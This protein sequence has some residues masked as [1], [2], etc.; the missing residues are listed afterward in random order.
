MGFQPS[1]F[2]ADLCARRAACA[3][4]L[5]AVGCQ[6][7]AGLWFCASRAAF[8]AEAEVSGFQIS[9]DIFLFQPN[10]A[11]APAADPLVAIPTDGKLGRSWGFA[12]ISRPECP[13]G[14]GGK[15]NYGAGS[16][17]NKQSAYWHLQRR[18]LCRHGT[19][20]SASASHWQPRQA[21]AAD[22]RSTPILST[23]LLATSL[24]SYYGTM[25]RIHIYS[26]S[27]DWGVRSG[28]GMQASKKNCD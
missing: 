27:S 1:L 16:I 3:P 26:I 14:T 8:E 7:G 28:A 25:G 15:I 12:Y 19:S 22:G 2:L 18:L 4:W 17:E 23:D 24:L 6:F 10:D 20:A 21:A 13:G 11:A 5:L 9:G